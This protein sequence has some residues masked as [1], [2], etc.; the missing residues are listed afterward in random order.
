MQHRIQR[1]H[2]VRSLKRLLAGSHFVEHN[3]KGKQVAPRVEFLAACLFRRHIN[4]CSGNYADRRERILIRSVLACRH[5]LVA[6]QFGQPKVQNLHL[7]G[8]RN[9]QIG[10]LD[11][12]MN[13]SLGV[14]CFKGLRHLYGNIEK[15]FKL[16]RFPVNALL[17]TLAFQPLHDDEGMAAVIVDFMDGANV[18]VI[19]PRRGPGFALEAVQ[20]LAVAQQIVGNELQGNMASEAHVFR[21]IDNA[22]AATADFSQNAIVGDCLADHEG[23]LAA[24]LGRLGAGVNHY[25]ENCQATLEMSPCLRH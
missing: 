21:L 2:Y 15:F 11:I 3:A 10:R 14:K 24:M 25:V 8:V 1:G 7:P 4:R 6:R 13:D 9:K 22:H 17:Q 20:R 16:Q 12:A 5:A 23:P 19:Q 18:G